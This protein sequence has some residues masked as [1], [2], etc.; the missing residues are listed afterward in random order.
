GLAGLAGLAAVAVLA[1]LPVVAQAPSDAVFK[2]FQPSGEFEIQLDGKALES[3]ELFHAERAASYLIMAPE[4]SSPLLV[5]ART[6]TVE[7]VSFMKVAKRP[8]G[9]IDL[10]ADASFQT[11]GP[12]AVGA[13]QLSFIYKGQSVVLAQKPP[14][15]GVHPPSKLISHNPDYGFKAEQYVPEDGHL[16]TLKALKKDVK[17]RVYFGN[18]CPVCSRLVPKVMKV[19]E[20]LAGASSVTFEYYGLPRRPSDDPVAVENKV[21]GVPTAIITVDGQEKGRLNGR[22][23]Y[24]PEAALGKLLAG[25]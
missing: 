7:Q 12:F 16:A 8:N 21:S 2:D 3:A 10:L 19:E 13:Q 23:L 25:S 4:I 14:L 5:N 24:K 22:D 9:T 20:S 1:A 18:W 17:V 6:R 11:V 15:T